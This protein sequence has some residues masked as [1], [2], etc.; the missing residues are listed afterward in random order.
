MIPRHGYSLDENKRPSKYG[1]RVR[2]VLSVLL[3]KRILQVGLTD[4][5]VMRLTDTFQRALAKIP[6]QVQ[7]LFLKT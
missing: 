7:K 4:I 5:G 3:E 1:K 2:R 6:R